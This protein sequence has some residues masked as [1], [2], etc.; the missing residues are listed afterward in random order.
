MTRGGGGGG[1]SL[2]LA[3]LQNGPKGLQQVLSSELLSPE[4]AELRT[5]TPNPYYQLLFG[6]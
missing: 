3:L 2:S 4:S 6:N 1:W 5:H